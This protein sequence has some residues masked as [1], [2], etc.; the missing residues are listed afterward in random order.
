[1]E[2]LVTSKKTP[3][4]GTWSLYPIWRGAVH[5]WTVSAGRQT[6][7]VNWRQN[8]C[9]S[10]STY[11]KTRKAVLMVVFFSQIMFISDNVGEFGSTLEFQDFHC[12]QK[13]SIILKSHQGSVNFSE[14]KACVFLEL[15]K[16]TSQWRGS[17][18]WAG[19]SSASDGLS[20]RAR[21]H[22]TSSYMKSLGPWRGEAQCN[23]SWPGHTTSRILM[24][25]KK[26]KT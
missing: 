23:L 21:L 12:E 17:D 15:W 4:Y 10:A 1:M 8:F 11:M 7:P 3:Q 19:W 13:G 26:K 9:V 20:A 18:R 5:G 22:S 2:C 14:G 6:A 25:S 16:P 24:L